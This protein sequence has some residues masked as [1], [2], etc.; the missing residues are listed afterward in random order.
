MKILAII[1]ARGGSKGV[2]KKNIK[3]LGKMPLIE[4]SINAAKASGKITAIVV[5]T[6]DAEIAIAAEV[7]GCKPPFVRPA[8]LAQDDTPSIEVVRHAIAFYESQGVFFEAICLLQPTTPFRAKGFIDEAIQK[9]IASGA[10]SLVSVLP[11]P[12]EYNP[13]WAF[14]ERETGLLKISTGESHIISRR[15]ELPKAYHRDGSV[16]LTKTEV[17]KSGSFY[18]NSIAFIESNAACY[19]NIDTMQDWEKAARMVDQFKG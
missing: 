6:D 15:Q 7:C 10:D 18:G 5:S 3:L 1:P 17:A 14:E 11:I 2:P 4:Y 19:V 16:Y 8:E 12:H 13:H 9:F